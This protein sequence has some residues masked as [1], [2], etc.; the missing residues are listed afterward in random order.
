MA[1]S[2]TRAPA[3]RSATRGG[4]AEWSGNAAQSGIA[5]VGDEAG[6]AYAVDGTGF[7]VLRDIAADADGAQDFARRVADQHTARDRDD[8][9]AGRNAQRL[10]ERLVGGGAAGEFAPAKT[11]A[12]GAPGL[13]AGDFGPQ[14]ARPSSRFIALSWP[15][16]S[17][18]TTVNGL[19]PSSRPFSKALSTMIEACSRFSTGQF[20]F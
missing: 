19:K 8:P 4:E 16:P 3:L 17:S 13:A 15:P 12:Q 1:S 18:T 11:H 9:A 5:G 6:A 20:H 14:Q 2:K 7:V 10:D